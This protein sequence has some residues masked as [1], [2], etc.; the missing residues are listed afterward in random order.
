MA[1]DVDTLLKGKPSK[2]FFEPL[3]LDSSGG[4][5]ARTRTTRRETGVGTS[6]EQSEGSATRIPVLSH[7][8]YYR[9]HL[10]QAVDSNPSNISFWEAIV[11]PH[12]NPSHPTFWSLRP[13]KEYSQRYTQWLSLTDSL[14]CRQR[15][16][17][18]CFETLADLSLGPEW[19]KPA[20]VHSLVL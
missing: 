19:K 16:I 18:R 13:A 6:G 9:N 2:F 11:P 1:G 12:S 8:S 4:I 20:S 10:F 14:Q 17:S 3:T 7:S 5:P 15:W